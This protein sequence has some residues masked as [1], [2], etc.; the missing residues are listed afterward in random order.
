MHSSKNMI[1]NLSLS[2][3]AAAV[4]LAFALLFSVLPITI[5]KKTAFGSLTNSPATVATTTQISLTAVTAAPLEAT[6]SC[7]ARIITTQGS[8]MLLTFS[9]VAGQ[10]PASGF[11]FIQ[12]A[13]TTVAYDA[14]QYGCGLVKAYSFGA[15]VITISDA[16]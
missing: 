4:L 1:K 7:T 2:L 11:G 16:R 6:S 15:Q 3:I 13:S 12:A 14:G 10:S 8:A 9:D 5:S